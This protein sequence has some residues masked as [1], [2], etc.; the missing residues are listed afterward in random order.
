M[1]E[2]NL[3][4]LVARLNRFCTRSLEGAAGLCI[5]RTNY[6]VTPEHL[7]SVMADDPTA[8]LQQ[9]FKHFNVDLGRVQKG[10]LRIIDG[11]KTGNA[12]RPTFSPVLLEWLQQAWLLA[13]LDF[14]L[15][16]IRSGIL[17]QSLL[18]NPTRLGAD[19]YME[20]FEGINRL[21][22]KAKYASIIVN[23]REDSKRLGSDGGTSTSPA[24]AGAPAGDT[25]LAKYANNFTA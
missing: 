13:S 25:A 24:A 1:V 14:N 10:M 2:V 12:G 4:A 16:E 15:A 18:A 11:L 6:E 22:L 20:L 3:K 21:D 23:S 9:I 5:Q 7:L 8:D 19:E 17:L